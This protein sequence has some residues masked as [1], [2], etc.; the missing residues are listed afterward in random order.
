MDGR[1][2]LSVEGETWFLFRLPAGEG[3]PV[4]GLPRWWGNAPLPQEEGPLC[5][6]H[7]PGRGPKGWGLCPLLGAPLSEL[8]QAHPE[9]ESLLRQAYASADR[10]SPVE[11][12]R[13]YPGSVLE[14]DFCN[15]HLTAKL[16]TI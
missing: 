11:N 2:A 14:M 10:E 12:G 4:T 7:H 13:T 8:S 15:L 5:R 6:W 16:G 1:P 3:M 9:L